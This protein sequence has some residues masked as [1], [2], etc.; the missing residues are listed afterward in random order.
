MSFESL[1]DRRP[2]LVR[3]LGIAAIAALFSSVVFFLRDCFIFGTICFVATVFMGSI[4]GA[5]CALTKKQETFY[6]WISIGICVAS[7]LILLINIF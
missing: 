5:S 7:L 3:F 4:C 2:R 6:I 1:L